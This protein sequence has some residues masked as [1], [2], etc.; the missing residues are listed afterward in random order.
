MGNRTRWGALVLCCAL[1]ACDDDKKSGTVDG[2]TLLDGSAGGGDGGGGDGSTAGGMNG[3]D[4]ALG[5]SATPGGDGGFVSSDGGG[6]PYPRNE[7]GQVLC[8]TTV[9]A[10][11]NGMDEDHDGLYD[12]ADPECVAAWD[13]DESSLATGISGDNRDDACQDCFFDGNSGAGDDGCRIA[14]SCF[15][16]PGGDS[17]SGRGSCD[18]CEATIECQ[19]FCQR[20][21]PNG[22]DCFGCCTVKLGDRTESVLLTG[23]CSIEGGVA[24]EACTRC[25]PS[26]TCLN[27][28][29]RCEL[30]PGK[31]RE[32]LP[33]DC[34]TSGGGD[35]G[36]DGGVG[37]G[38][39][40]VPYTCDNGEAR[41]GAGLP[42]CGPNEI[43]TYG[44][45]ILV[46]LL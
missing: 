12:T 5:D 24:S 20:Y 31:T 26:T 42:A 7:I 38:D 4:A 1:I 16:P 19:D 41:C 45:C 29:G 15:T 28:C 39:G 14:S 37:G 17:S 44:C 23:S 40:G 3:M 9:C 35:A 11:S 2:G 30:C 18:T 21:T 32:D 13:N 46:P 10:C 6:V 25:V 36:T 8:G 43:C 34:T 33:A 27:A 22:C